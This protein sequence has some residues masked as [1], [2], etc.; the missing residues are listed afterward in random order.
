MLKLEELAVQVLINFAN[1]GQVS[2]PVAVVRGAEDGHDAPLVHPAVAVAD[3]LVRSH[4]ELEAVRVDELLA[5]VLAESVAR[6]TGGD[7][8]AR[9]LVRVTPKQV[10]HRTLVR[11]LLEPRQL[12]DVADGVQAGRQAGVGAEEL[13]V[14]DGGDGQKVEQIRDHLPHVRRAVLPQALVVEAVHLG[15]LARLVVAPDDRDALGVPHLEGEHDLNSLHRV[16]PSVH[17]VAEEEEVGAG[18]RARDLKEL[19]DVV[20]LPVHV[21]DDRHRTAHGRHVR[22]RLK[23]LLAL[24]AQGLYV[25]LREQLA[26]HEVVDVVVQLAR[27]RQRQYVLLSHLVLSP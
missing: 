13:V 6:P 22:L 26:L 25:L 4:D 16:V 24:L 18:R 21:P 23:D 14:Y 12:V 8:P 10:A 20:V 27:I 17:V 7:T 5:H 19:H 1:G 3:Q 2:T 11:H 15:D 9:P